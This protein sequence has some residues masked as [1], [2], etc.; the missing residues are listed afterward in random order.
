MRAVPSSFVILLA[1]RVGIPMAPTVIRKRVAVILS[2]WTLLSL[3]FVTQVH[4]S[5][6]SK[7][8]DNSTIANATKA[9]Q[10]KPSLIVNMSREFGIYSDKSRTPTKDEQVALDL[11]NSAQNSA[12]RAQAMTLLV[13]VK[14]K[15]LREVI[16]LARYY[17]NAYKEADKQTARLQSIVQNDTKSQQN[18][19]SKL[20][21]EVEQALELKKRYEDGQEK[22]QVAAKSLE[23][24]QK[25]AED[26]FLSKWI[27]RRIEDVGSF[28]DDTDAGKALGQAVGK[29]FDGARDSVLTFEKS[30]ETRVPSK[31]LA[32]LLCFAMFV[33]PVLICVTM[34][35]LVSVSMSGRQHILLSHVFYFLVAVACFG[36]SLVI[37]YDPIA[38]TRNASNVYNLVLT[39][40]AC[41]HW[42]IIILLMVFTI[43]SSKTSD[44]RHIFL[45]EIMLFVVLSRH[46]YKQ[47]SRVYDEILA[48]HVYGSIPV[49]FYA[50]YAVSFAVMI[51]MTV[52]AS[53]L[54]KGSL[55]SAVQSTMD[56]GAFSLEKAV[57]KFFRALRGQSA[58]FSQKR[59]SSRMF[60]RAVSRD[61]EKQQC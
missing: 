24:S 22:L 23:S 2:T 10:D 50:L 49:Y 44:E 29:A 9:D 38:Y 20:R 8:A 55:D 32:L 60:S 31:K 46:F 7:T 26:P 37:S 11:V 61:L 52:E 5:G 57:N 34:L 19:T 41:C 48:A 17:Y 13:S 4:S 47:S 42:T 54:R 30:L 40:V 6:D 53:S 14:D 58:I 3:T 15:K 35:R 12:D 45:S 28:V 25:N 59:L 51:F 43:A 27:Q 36:M 56:K 18:L 39:I 33:V 16:D 21:Q 1:F